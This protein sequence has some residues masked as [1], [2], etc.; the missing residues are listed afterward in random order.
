MTPCPVCL[1]LGKRISFSEAENNFD[2]KTQ[3]EIFCR[4]STKDEIMF[5]VKAVLTSM[6]SGLHN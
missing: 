6:Y 2:F 3:A 1:E 5:A 4:D